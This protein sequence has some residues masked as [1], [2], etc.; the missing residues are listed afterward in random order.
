MEIGFVCVCAHVSWYRWIPEVKH[1]S[2]CVIRLERRRCKAIFFAFIPVERCSFCIDGR[3]LSNFAA[4]NDHTIHGPHNHYASMQ[5][6][7]MD[8]F[9]FQYRSI[10]LFTWTCLYTRHKNRHQPHHL[11][12]I[13]LFFS[14]SRPIV[15]L[16]IFK[17]S[18]Y[19]MHKFRY[20]IW[21]IKML[22]MNIQMIR[23]YA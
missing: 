18:L 5:T 2:E 1:S 6:K 23:Y 21:I 9:S 3:H 20:F 12:F 8:T 14:S 15:L 7:P 11:H 10:S 4:Q 22:R 16:F 17:N 13:S 19:F